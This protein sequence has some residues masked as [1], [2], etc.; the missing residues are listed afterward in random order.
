MKVKWM[1]IL[2]VTA[3]LTVSV[4]A[5]NSSVR[6]DYPAFNKTKD[7]L[8]A[9]FDCFADA[10]DIHSQAA[11][12]CMLIHPDWDDINVYAVLGATGRQNVVGFIGNAPLMDL[13]FGAEGDDTWTY[14]WDGKL[15]EGANWSRSVTRV[16]N[17]VK[18]IL[19]N[20]GKVWVMAAGQSNI[21]ADWIAALKSEGVADATIKNNVIVV[22]HSSWNHSNSSDS[23]YIESNTTWIKIDDGNNVNGTPDYELSDTA[24]M[25]SAVS[26]S[27]PNASARTAWTYGRDFIE[28]FGFNNGHSP[29]QHGGVD[30]SD[31]VEAGWILNELSAM[32][33]VQKFWDKYVT[34]A[35]SGTMPGPIPAPMT[36]KPYPPA[37]TFVEQGGLVVCEMESIPGTAWQW[38]YDNWTL[39]PS[40]W[41]ETSDF[42]GGTG[43][44]YL[45]Y[46]SGL[47]PRTHQE[48]PLLDQVGYNIRITTPGTYELG[49]RNQ[50]GPGANDTTYVDKENDSFLT[51]IADDFYCLRNGGVKV[52]LNGEYWKL[53]EQSV[54]A[55]TW[56]IKLMWNEVTEARSTDIRADFNSPGV[57]RVIVGGRSHRHSLDRLVLW[58]VDSVSESYAKD[59]SRPESLIESD[60]GS[61]PPTVSITAPTAGASF[62][63]TNGLD[64]AV[65][66]T[67]SD[68][69]VSN[70]LLLIDGVEVSADTTT[71][72]EWM[73][74][75]LS[76]LSEGSH[77]LTAVATD[78]EGLTASHNVGFIIDN[79]LDGEVVLKN[80]DGA[81]TA[82]KTWTLS[83]LNLTDP[84]VSTANGTATGFF[85]G[86][87]NFDPTEQVSLVAD[88]LVGWNTADAQAAAAG[89]TFDT[90]L[91]GLT[92]VGIGALQTGEFGVDSGAGDAEN[93]RIGGT[94]TPNEAMVF[95]VDLSNLLSADHITL[96]SIKLHQFVAADRADFVIVDASE[97]TLAVQAWD[98]SYNGSDSIDGEW[99]L[100]DGDRIV[101]GTGTSMGSEIGYRITSLTLDVDAAPNVPPAVQIDDPADGSAFTQA[102]LM[103]VVASASDSDGVVADVTLQLDDSVYG[104]DASAPYEWVDID[105]SG[106]STGT[107][108]LTAVAVDNKGAATTNT[109]S[110]EI[111]E[112]GDGVVF[113]NTDAAETADK[114]WTITGLN[115]VDPMVS[116]A[117]GSATGVF[118]GTGSFDPAESI[119]IAADGYSGWNTA[120]AQAAVAGGTFDGYLSG[121]TNVGVGALQTGEFGVDSGAGDAQNTRIGGTGVPNEALVFTVDLGNLTTADHITLSMIKLYQF[122]ATDRVDFLIVGAS[123]GTVTEQA[124]DTSYNST[125][126][127]D[128]NWQLE[129]GDRIVIGAGVSMGSGDGYRIT[130]LTLDIDSLGYV[131]WS[132]DYGL[133]EGRFGDDDGDGESNIAEFY[134]GGNPTNALH[135]SMSAIAP[136]VGID[137]VNLVFRRRTQLP[138]G[139]V[140]S[141]EQTKNL[142]DAAWTNA[143]FTVV[144]Q[145]VALDDPDYLVVTNQIETSQ[146]NQFFRV[147]VE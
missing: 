88:G 75:D 13:I 102:S 47:P 39:V 72:Y 31:V 34:N 64:V 54:D 92:N 119:S 62:A 5:A 103:T 2:S 7:L 66:A 48:N 122:V 107:H 114:T 77:T 123:A 137:A 58:K 50:S 106:L 108:V 12:G 133:T 81:E 138:A 135:G 10:D 115:Q 27:N 128:G 33:T 29:I 83:G 82:D 147:I 104:T 98:T 111:V 70:V 127:I 124:W 1:T 139:T 44:A 24:Y 4:H 25:T 93:T 90:Y 73:G 35:T 113:K 60:G 100:E 30:F 20:G 63:S 79:S 110:F 19:L 95:T 11:L 32:D 74:L 28:A 22:Q 71:P 8:L 46:D 6:G 61:L 120:D 96:S 97:G 99:Q 136:Q 105:L 112:P 89:G 101:I 146:S 84:T 87:G 55:W 36:P 38:V 68:G 42:S 125:D 76:G 14:A 118:A 65:T 142:V 18:P 80:T 53:F 26:G 52:D 143:D 23:A 129:D 86:M 131:N 9:Q 94:G 126:S 3:C 140:Y 130:S 145:G 51:V 116:T 15:V 56:I 40:V 85:S 45:E 117:N 144:G 41:R 16:K 121:L 109:V 69:S 132:A 141:I 78:D 57:Y 37:K 43:G 21:T 49:F 67:D 134:F 91:S 17:K 59:L